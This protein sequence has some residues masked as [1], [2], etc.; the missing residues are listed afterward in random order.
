MIWVIGIAFL[1]VVV[2][3]VAVAK[4]SI[5]PSAPEK[6]VSRDGRARPADGVFD[7]WTSNDLAQMLSQLDQKTPLVDRHFLLMGIVGETYKQREIPKMR[8]TCRQIAEL[9]ISE[10]TKIKP[11][12]KRSLGVLPRVPTFQQYA[13]LLTEDA[14]FDRAIKVCNQAIK[15]GLADG[16]KSGFEGRIERIRKKQARTRKQ[17]AS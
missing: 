14:D 2:I 3:V 6:F 8:E 4:A 11:A 13:S 1:V 15:F 10:F 12:L 9:H 16:T 5:A 7:A 17:Q